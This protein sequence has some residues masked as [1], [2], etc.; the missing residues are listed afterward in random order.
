MA[1][2]KQLLVPGDRLRAIFAIVV[3]ED[4]AGRIELLYAE[5]GASSPS[6]PFGVADARERRIVVEVKARPDWDPRAVAFAVEQGV[7][8]ALRDA[9]GR[10]NSDG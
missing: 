3:K 5:P 7:R 6:D 2:P 9:L 8:H 4:G 1:D 10:P